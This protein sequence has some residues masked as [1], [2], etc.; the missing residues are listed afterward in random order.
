MINSAWGRLG[1]C[2]LQIR[3]SIS[4]TVGQFDV[5][6][7]EP[8]PISSGRHHRDAKMTHYLFRCLLS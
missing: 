8:V 4:P 2:Q 1:C 3:L 6:A 5:E 7:A